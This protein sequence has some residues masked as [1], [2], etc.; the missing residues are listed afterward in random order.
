MI[1]LQE[2]FYMVA[3]TDAGQ[4]IARQQVTIYPTLPELEAFANG[5]QQAD[6]IK[7]EKVL[8]YVR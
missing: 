3:Y 7:V 5:Y 2:A 4:I 1:S 8:H 6:Y